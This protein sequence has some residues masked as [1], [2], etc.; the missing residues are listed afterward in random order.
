MSTLPFA[1][2]VLPGPAAAAAAAAAAAVAAEGARPAAA[3]AEPL[4]AVP[5]DAR[6]PGESIPAPLLP[7]RRAAKPDSTMREMECERMLRVGAAVRPGPA[8]GTPARAGSSGLVTVPLP[9][10]ALAA[11]AAAAAVAADTPLPPFLP[12]WPAALSLPPLPRSAWVLWPPTLAR[13]P[14]L[15]DAMTGSKAKRFWAS[16]V[17]AVCGSEE[18]AR[19]GSRSP[20]EEPTGLLMSAPGATSAPES[21]TMPA[22]APPGRPVP[23]PARTPATRMRPSSSTSPLAATA[24]ASR[25]ACCASS[26]FDSRPAF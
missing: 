10:A 2:P 1:G 25:A 20:R 13:S 21:G 16:C 7:P 3:P 14:A 9:P 5:T 12:L 22:S 19:P 24:S 23:A 11:A 8:A 18:S 17:M 6:P 26:G 15:P 4:P